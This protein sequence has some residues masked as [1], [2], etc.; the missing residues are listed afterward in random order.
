MPRRG[1]GGGDLVKLGIEDEWYAKGGPM[2]EAV[3]GS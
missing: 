3:G 2:R 1:G